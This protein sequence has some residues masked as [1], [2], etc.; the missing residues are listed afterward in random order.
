MPTYDRLTKQKRY[1]I[2]AMR[3][4]GNP[5]KEIARAIG[6]H[7]STVSRELRRGATAPGTIATSPDNAMRT[8]ASGRDTGLIPR[9]SPSPGRR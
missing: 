7:P 2:E 1:T 4:N 5:Q 3:R 9:S 6:V 8:P